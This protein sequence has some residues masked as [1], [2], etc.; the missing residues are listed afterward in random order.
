MAEMTRGELYVT[1]TMLVLIGWNIASNSR[2]ISRVHD[3]VEE[4]R[5]QLTG[6]PPQPPVIKLQ[7]A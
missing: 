6:V 3:E 1:W 4:F 7:R 2:A 5:R